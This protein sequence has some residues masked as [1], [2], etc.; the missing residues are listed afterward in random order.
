MIVMPLA[1]QDLE[2]GLTLFSQAHTILVFIYCMLTS[3][4]SFM[5][6]L[7]KTELLFP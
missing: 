7:V 5:F 6:V 1:G 4:L 2:W 3:C